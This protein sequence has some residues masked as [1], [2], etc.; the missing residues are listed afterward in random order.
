MCIMCGC[1]CL[2]VLFLV[3][4]SHFSLHLGLLHQYYIPIHILYF[5]IYS[6][7]D[8]LMRFL[9]GAHAS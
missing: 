3:L 8:N 7:I 1:I 6:I 5:L 9:I 2:G 4:P